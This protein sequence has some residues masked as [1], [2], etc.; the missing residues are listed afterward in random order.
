MRP[1]L[2][3]FVV[4]LFLSSCRVKPDSPDPYSVAA[5]VRSAPEFTKVQ[6]AM[7]TNITLWVVADAL[8]N[9][10]ENNIQSVVDSYCKLSDDRN[11]PS[12]V[13]IIN[14]ISD[15]DA[16]RVVKWQAVS[17][18][19][20]NL[21]PKFFNPV[22]LKMQYQVRIE[23]VNKKDSQSLDF[24]DKVILPGNSGKVIAISNGN[25]TNG[26]EYEYNIWFSIT[27]GGQTLLFRIDPKLRG[28]N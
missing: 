1:I 19:S 13:P 28:N 20:E 6:S 26:E 18:E 10:P 27:H 7:N 9:D 5:F 25:A 17:L 2:F 8:F 24:F 14:F 15:V 11:N 23:Q 16:A 3:L 12:P 22:D 4:S 21:D